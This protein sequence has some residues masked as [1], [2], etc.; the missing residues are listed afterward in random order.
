MIIQTRITVKI[1]R[2]CKI[3]SKTYQEMSYHIEEKHK[4]DSTIKTEANKVIQ[5]ITEKFQTMQKD[6]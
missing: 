4:Q 6:R 1:K 2:I 3:S 5:S